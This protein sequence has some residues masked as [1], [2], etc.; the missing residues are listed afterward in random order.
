MWNEL[1][2]WFN[3][4]QEGIYMSG[5]H[6]DQLYFEQM[7]KRKLLTK[8]QEVELGNRVKAGD[9][10]AREEF[11]ESNLRLVLK[12]SR[13]YSYGDK[14]LEQDLRQEGNKELIRVVGN[15]DPGLGFRFSS[16]A[17]VCIKGVMLDYLNS[18]KHTIRIPGHRKE[19]IN[20]I[21]KISKEN[22][23]S[24]MH[25]TRNIEIIKE[26]LNYK[27]SKRNG[28]KFTD[29]DIREVVSEYSMLL[30]S[31]LDEP[32]FNDNEESLCDSIEDEKTVSPQDEV[33]KSKLHHAVMEVV[34][35]MENKMEKD[36]IIRRYGL[37]GRHI[38]KLDI[39]GE[40]WGVTMEI[41]R[42]IE[43]VAIRRLREKMKHLR[44][45]VYPI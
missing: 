34:E 43:A 11:I 44:D 41:V 33:E 9:M 12:Y 38:E 6:V 28:E 5:E 19:L 26:E 15:F 14:K 42:Q 30:V 4:K 29:S 23:I 27:Y 16:Y 24:D 25:S 10:Q 45:E 22:G 17:T 39:I 20:K 36:I 2:H 32:K 3:I 7:S 31:S 1:L 35:S 18:K 13:I 21:V 40:S 8:E 37:N